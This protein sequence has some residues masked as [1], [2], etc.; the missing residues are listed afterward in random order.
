MYF[1]ES[2]NLL[3]ILM[4]VCVVCDC[5]GEHGLWWWWGRDDDHPAQLHQQTWQRAEDEEADHIASRGRVGVGE[6]CSW[7][8]ILGNTI[9]STFC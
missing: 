8:N 7:L 2:F 3:L 4:K 5:S 1:V 9:C 6:V